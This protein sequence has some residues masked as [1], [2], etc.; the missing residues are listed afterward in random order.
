MGMNA[1]KEKEIFE[2]KPVLYSIFSLALPSV[3]GQIILVLYNLAD[4]FFV[5]LT[6]NSV[7][8]NAVGICMPVYTMLTAISNLFGIGGSSVISRSLGKGNE[9]RAR[10]ASSFAF[11]GSLVVSA[12]YCL[13]ILIFAE[14]IANLIGGNGDAMLI[15][16]AASYLRIC[17]SLCGIPT[18]ISNLLSHLLRSQGKSLHAS[19]GIALGGVLNIAL[20]PLFIFVICGVENAAVGA[21]IATGIANTLAMLY[22][23][24]VFLVYKGKLIIDLSFT[25][26]IFKDGLISEVLTIGLPACLMTLCE[27]ISYAILGNLMGSVDKIN[28]LPLTGVEVAKKVNMFA[29]SVVR[30]MSQGVLPLIGYNKASG[31]RKRMKK[32]VFTAGGISLALAILAAAVNIIPF[33]GKSLISLF[34]HGEGE[35]V[36]NSQ[37]FAYYFLIMFS[38]GAPFSAVA[39]TIISF[40]QACGKAWR[41]LILALLRKGI[42]DIPLMFIIPLMWPTYGIVA[43]TPIADAI[44][45]AVAVVLFLYYIK[46]HAKDVPPAETGKMIEGTC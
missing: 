38:I 18:V 9:K 3:I 44:C 42:L 2:S 4:T 17:V 6:E 27:N 40:F 34:L 32:V 41:S 16:Q 29:H 39:Y 43:A 30:G 15:S 35:N 25:K 33:T 21:A 19:L 46:R 31:N 24:I 36:I 45:C 5:G 10:R 13:I 28:K 8:I 1:S 11:W 22:Y 20:D 7:M 12:L 37:Q 23:V 26:K 14:Q